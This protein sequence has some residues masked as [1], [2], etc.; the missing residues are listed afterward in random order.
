[1]NPRDIGPEIPSAQDLAAFAKEYFKSYMEA[2]GEK[3]PQTPPKFA[4]EAP[5]LI[6]CIYLPNGCICMIF[7]SSQE[8]KV[9]SGTKDWDNVQELIVKGV[10]HFAGFFPFEGRSL[11]DWNKRGRRDA[12]RDVRLLDKSELSKSGAELEGT[13]ENVMRMVKANPW[14]G[15]SGTEIVTTLRSLESRVKQG[16]PTVD[17]IATLQSLKTYVPGADSVTI[18]FPDKEL[19]ESISDGIKNVTG[20]ENKLEMIENRI[21]EVE[22]TASTEDETAL[23]AEV[24]ERVDRLEKQLEKVSN[25]LTMLNSKVESYF[26]KTAEKE[27]QADLERRIED[28]LG[29]SI[30]H[31]SKIQSLEKEA[32]TLVDEMRRMTAKMEKDI[33]DSRK[34]IARM[35]KHFVDLAKMIQE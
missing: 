9:E 12:H 17:A 23:A 24:Q 10:D 14:L 1:M 6:R 19:L 25:I 31:D 35:E 30:E 15:R 26:S 29:R 18:D 3:K 32:L 8:L 33:H 16:F 27:R 7:N 4:Q 21:F 22:K 2:V 34:R 11:G 13:I 28:H 20:I 5:Y